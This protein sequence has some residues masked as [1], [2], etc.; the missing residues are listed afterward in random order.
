MSNILASLLV[1]GL[2]G[3]CT[4]KEAPPIEPDPVEAK[5]VS[6][7]AA[8]AVPAKPVQRKLQVE[9]MTCGGCVSTVTHLLK[10]VPGVKDAKV[11]LETGLAEITCGENV[12]AQTLIDT[13]EGAENGGV[14]LSYKAKEVK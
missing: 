6:V 13:L 11:S 3:G 8:T 2:L 14:K 9:G 10:S 7:T 1:F 4:Q 5:P 12:S